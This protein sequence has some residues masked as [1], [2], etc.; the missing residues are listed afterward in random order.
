MALLQG[1]R[2]LQRSGM[3]AKVCI[4]QLRQASKASSGSRRAARVTAA[5]TQ[6]AEAPAP[7]VATGDKIKVRFAPSPTGNLHVGGARTALFNWLYAR[8]VGGKFVLRVEDTDTARSTRE[9]EEAMKE[10]LRWL[11]LD[12]DEGPDVG[13]DNG[14][15][16]QSERAQIYKEYVDQLVAKGVAYPCFCTDEELEAMKKEAEEKKLPPIYR[17]KWSSA[18]KEEVDAM[19]ASGATCC[20]RF[21]VPPGKE[22]FIDDIVRGRVTW[23]TDTLGDFVILRSNGLPVYNF[24]V[25]IDDALMGITHVLRAEE[26]LPNTLRQVLIYQALNFT[27]PAFGHMSLILA[28]DKSKLSK[29]H[30]ATSVG[31]FKQQAR[32]ALRGTGNGGAGLRRLPAAAPCLRQ[33][34]VAGLRSGGFL[35]PAMVNYLS[36]LGWNDGT[37]KEIYSVDELQTAFALERITKSPA[38]FDRVKL[39]WMNG[40]H[41]RALPEEELLGRIGAALVADGVVT[42]PDS[43]F[44]KALAGLVKGSVELLTDCAAQARPLLSY[45]LAE[46]V[47]SEEFKPFLE[48]NFAEV[49][50]AVVAASDSGELAAAVAAGHDGYKKWVNSVGK[51]QKRKGKRLFMP[52][53]VAFT[54]RMQGPDV[55][56]LLPALALA[57][58]GDVAESSSLVPLAQRVEQLREWVGKQQ[59]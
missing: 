15:Y 9:S 16:R 46:T 11:G 22:I 23:N 57:G 59:A 56:D 58:D 6:V 39:S 21:R 10:D 53:R 12:W 2:L 49:A 13:G 52:M 4:L 8:K 51:A 24:C 5:A 41:L 45:P 31:E 36:L 28:P 55:G 33:G 30:G 29:R 54:G 3:Q 27:P 38:V 44:A 26:H 17:G 47:A 42:S 37:E 14:P 34:G 43:A 32:A 48:D 40:Q 18:S 19:L 20:Y 50:Q 25:A 1:Q 7:A 35:A